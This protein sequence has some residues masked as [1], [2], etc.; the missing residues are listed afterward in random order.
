MERQWTVAAKREGLSARDRVLAERDVQ[1][2]TALES[3]DQ[4]RRL[5]GLQ[6]APPGP[7]SNLADP[8]AARAR[9]D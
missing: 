5:A 2:R 9:S 4:A 6:V 1:I 3:F 7:P 8:G